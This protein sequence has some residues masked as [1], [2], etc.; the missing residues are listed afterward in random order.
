MNN[1]AE[2]LTIA[3]QPKQERSRQRFG[4]VLQTAEQIL[5]DQGLSQF[6]IP[7]IAERLH[8]S[9]NAI[10]KFFP[11]P[12]AVLNELTQL[13]LQALEAR[14][15]DESDRSPA[16]SWQGMVE[17][18]VA[19]A[20]EFYNADA[21]ASMLILGGSATDE[22]Y[23]LLELTIQHLGGQIRR[24]MSAYGQQLPPEPPDIATLAVEIGSAAFRLSYLTHQRITPAY[25]TE[26]TTAMVAYLSV[27]LK[28]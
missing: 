18:I 13:R 23:R 6:S 2:D 20:V 22:S 15:I 10:Y 5:R 17:R 8:C 11:T 12:Y 19:T 28:S 4:D 3:R 24:M 21:V 1:T 25:Q 27:R 26:A 14:L 7:Q 9:R 16:P